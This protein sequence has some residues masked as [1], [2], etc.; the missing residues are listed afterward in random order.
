M[1]ASTN[2][3]Q[4]TVLIASDNRNVVSRFVSVLEPRYEVSTACNQDE[5]IACL[6]GMEPAV[7][8]VD[9]SLYES[10]DTTDQILAVVRM[11]A[12][13]HVIVIENYPEC[14]VDQHLLF[15]AGAHGFCKSD[16]SEPLLQKAVELV[17]DGDYWV[18]RKLIT[19]V[20]SD[21]AAEKSANLNSNFDRTLVSTLTPREL[22]VAKLVHMGENN[23]SI[24]RELDISERT[25]KAHL[26]AIFRKLDIENRL[27]LALF[28]SELS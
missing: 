26:S 17:L 21:M 28:F 15:K 20:I 8:I 6:T 13:T 14:E 11:S 7:L 24:A 19:Q 23:K 10:G 5:M 12:G 18:Q 25:V 1:P 2:K 22:Q 4:D 27:N 3:N 9:P 16:I